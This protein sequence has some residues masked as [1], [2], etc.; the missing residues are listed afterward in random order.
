M[1]KPIELKTYHQQVNQN[2]PPESA[3]RLMTAKVPLVD[4]DATIAGIEKM[5]LEKI[6]E[7]ETINYIY[8][9]DKNKKLKGVISLKDVFRLPKATPVSQVITKDLVSVRPYADQEKVALLALQNN[10]KAIPVVDKKNHLL[11][12]VPSDVILNILHSENIEDILRFAGIGKLKNPAISIIKAS[13]LLHFRKRLPW[14][15]LG[16]L[17]GVA[18][19]FIVEFFE[20]ALKSQLILAA[21]IPAVV[22][23]ADAVGTQTQT[24]FIRSLALDRKLNLKK[25]LFREVKVNFFLALVLG[26][27]ISIISLLWWQSSLLGAILGISIFMTV[28]TAMV[29][30]IFLPWLFSKTKHDP[31][32]ASGPFATVIRDILSLLIYF[33]IAQ[34]MLNIF[35]IV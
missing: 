24:I 8:I 1:T 19:A 18:A 2:F 22:Y 32:I 14:L 3:A 17:G 10:L 6:K 21:F 7:L 9:V 25:Y 13:A 15:I 23:M 12:I 27:I 5:L 4:S 16:L 26:I 20:E 29:V 34:I 33:S 28:L 35:S 11:G 30:A 31:A